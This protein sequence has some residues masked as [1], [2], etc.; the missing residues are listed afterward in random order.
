MCIAVMK[1]WE[2][3]TEAKQKRISIKRSNDSVDGKLISYLKSDPF[4]EDEDLPTLITSTLKAYWLPLALFSQ[5]VRG[6]KLRQAG[7]RAISKL[8]AQIST[9]RRICGI[10][11]GLGIEPVIA[12]QTFTRA[13]KESTSTLGLISDNQETNI[14]SGGNADPNKVATDEDW[15]WNQEY[16][17]MELE[18]PEELRDANRLLGFG[19]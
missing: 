9:I 17:L 16:E 4:D 5:G 19:Q 2:N 14:N 8:E 13:S 12:H 7:I 6:E 11:A 18:Q 3:M 15:Y 1:I 10:D